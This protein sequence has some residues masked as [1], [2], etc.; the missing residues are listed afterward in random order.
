[1]DSYWNGGDAK[2]AAALL[3]GVTLHGR[4]DIVQ[5]AFTEAAALAPNRLDLKF[6]IASTQLIQKD[7]AGA[8]ATYADILAKDPAAFEAY[9][10]LASLDRSEG[11][12]AGA[13]GAEQAMAALNPARAAMLHRR[14]RSVEDIM[15]APLDTAPRAFPGSLTIVTL[16]YAL[17]PTGAMERPLLDRLTATL[18]AARANPSANIVVT[19]GQPQAGATEADVMMRWLVAHGV[20]RSRVEIEDKARDTVGNALNSAVR[21]ARVE[22]DRV[23]LV[24]SASHMRRAHALMQAALAQAGLDLPLATLAAPDRTAG[25][26]SADERM[27]VYRDILRVSGVWAYPGLQR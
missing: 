9:A 22:P 23:L 8:R 16:G 13:A 6:A 27:A 4:Y 7:E 19:G 12:E 26:P 21:I 25:P 10:W 14:F 18:A 3:K 20:E 24:T 1:M 5:R 15:A 17:S 11:D 2:A